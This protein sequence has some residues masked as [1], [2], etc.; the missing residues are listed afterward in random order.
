MESQFVMNVA[1]ILLLSLPFVIAQ[2]VNFTLPPSNQ[3]VDEFTDVTFE[4]AANNGTHP[5]VV[6]WRLRVEGRP[7]VFIGVNVSVEGTRGAIVGPNNGS[8]LTLTAVSRSLHGVTVSCAARI[9]IAQTVEQDPP[10]YLSVRYQYQ[11]DN[12]SSRVITFN[13]DEPAI[14]NFTVTVGNPPNAILILF[15]NTTSVDNSKYT[16]NQVSNQLWQVTLRSLT[17]ADSGNYS[18]RFT[19]DAGTA[20]AHFQLI[21]RCKFDCVLC[22]VC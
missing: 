9:N 7:T 19:N 14:I 12:L 16:V 1:L 11:F 20:E 17:T 13:E 3:T 5:F 2:T 22:S 18:A 8:P 4:C 10:F 15:F 21:V 6:N